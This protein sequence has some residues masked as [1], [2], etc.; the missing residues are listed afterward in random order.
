MECNKLLKA[1]QNQEWYTKYYHSLEGNFTQNEDIDLGLPNGTI[2]ANRNLETDCTQAPGDT[3]TIDQAKSNSTWKLPS[4]AQFEELVNYCTWTI[5]N[6]RGSV[7]HK[8]TGPNGENMFLPAGG[9]D[10]CKYY[11]NSYYFEGRYIGDG[12][13]L[14]VTSN[15]PS[16]PT[17]VD[18]ERGLVRPVK[19]K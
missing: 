15:G 17:P 5:A 11:M 1:I 13:A 18:F 12:N 8:I 10:S 19:S 14:N 6:Y 16:T 3:Y 2:W 4:T 9:N 7:G